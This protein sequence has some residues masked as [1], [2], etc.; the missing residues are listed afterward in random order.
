MVSIIKL[1]RKEMVLELKNKAA[2]GS[3][4]LYAVASIYISYLCFRRITDVP[5]WNALF[6]I[7]ILFA[8]FNVAGRS[9]DK[10]G[11]G[12]EI[13]LFT[14]LSP[15]GIIIGKMVFNALLMMVL[16]FF[17]LLVFV[18]LLGGQVWQQADWGMVSLAVLMGGAG[19]GL[20]L[21][22]IAGIAFKTDNHMGLMAILGF[23]VI[24]PYLLT[25]V[26]FSKNSLDGIDWSVNYPYFLTLLLLDGVVL[27]LGYILFP[28]LWR[29]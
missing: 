2:L 22:L 24:L 19:F 3:M 5:T 11:N 7:I 20:I 21:T 26:R 28:Y 4:L 8:S 9:F 10:E 13:Y 29:D 17:S 12:R 14:L 15:E 27:V 6:W 23:P 1:I 18:L 16:G 25:L